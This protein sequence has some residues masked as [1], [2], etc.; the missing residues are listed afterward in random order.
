MF[1]RSHAV[2]ATVVQAPWSVV[3]GSGTGSVWRRTSSPRISAA[4]SVVRAPEPIFASRT[5]NAFVGFDRPA[6]AGH[7]SFGRLLPGSLAGF[8][9]RSIGRA[10]SRRYSIGQRVGHSFRWFRPQDY[11]KLARMV[12]SLLC[13]DCSCL[14]FRELKLFCLY[15]LLLSIV[16]YFCMITLLKKN[17]VLNFNIC[18]I[19]KLFVIFSW[20]RTYDLLKQSLFGWTIKNCE[21]WIL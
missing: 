5:P 21:Y 14:F 10:P 13:G 7:Q 1:Y 8:T 18:I 15:L 9:V 20:N 17:K 2:A 19:V 6:L 11:W 4:Q 3:C 16:I 12:A